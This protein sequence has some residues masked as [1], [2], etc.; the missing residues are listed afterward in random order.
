MGAG[1]SVVS[2]GSE[3]AALSEHCSWS[4]RA[5]KWR[6]GSQVAVGAFNMVPPNPALQGT[7]ATTARAPELER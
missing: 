7:R 5:V 4:V 3:V 2:G 6:S 1:L